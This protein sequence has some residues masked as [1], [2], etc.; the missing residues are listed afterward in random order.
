MS[1]SQLVTHTNISPN[2]S[3]RTHAIDTIAIH[4]MAG[5]MTVESCGQLF[6]NAKRQASSNYG[7]DDKGHVG[8]Y[9]HESRRS[10]CTSSSTVDN[11][12]VTI[13]VAS[14]VYNP[15][16]VTDV[17]YDKLIELV[18]DIC[19]RNGIKKLVW[20]T[21]KAKRKAWADGCNM[22]VH[23]DW[24]AKACPGDYLYNR[25]GDIA[26]KV[27]DLIGADHTPSPAP[28][29][30]PAPVKNPVI[31]AQSFYNSYVHRGLVCDGIW[32]ALTNDSA[33]RSM[34]KAVGTDA[35]GIIGADTK[36]C[37]NAHL[38]GKGSEGELVRVLQATLTKYGHDLDFD[39]DFGTLTDKA[40]RSFQT[41]HGLDA[42]GIVGFNT[43]SAL[44]R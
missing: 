41:S 33:V 42:D 17:A 30:D 37:I 3:A 13:E 5:H 24:D 16:N 1:N 27:N 18:A 15:C 12:A 7:V 14:D 4:C 40:V 11:R 9:V 21:D 2:S 31:R 6:A 34:Q 43:W 38:I 35:D 39:G 28:S 36:R 26:Q 32:G 25:M 23:R 29:V 10:W 44:L 8:L 22:M 19:K 20:S